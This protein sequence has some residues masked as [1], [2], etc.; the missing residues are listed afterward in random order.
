MV[1]LENNETRYPKQNAAI[2]QTATFA[3][4]CAATEKITKKQQKQIKK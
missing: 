1:A 3:A 2:L 4:D